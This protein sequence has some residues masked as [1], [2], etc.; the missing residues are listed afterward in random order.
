M[1]ICQSCSWAGRGD[2]IISFPFLFLMLP[3]RFLLVRS[4]WPKPLLRPI[5][6]HSTAGCPVCPPTSLPSGDKALRFSGLPPPHPPFYPLRHE[7]SSPLH[8]GPTP[9]LHRRRPADAEPMVAPATLAL[10]P[11]AAP[12]QPRAALP[13]A[14]ASWF[15]PAIIRTSPSVAASY[16]P[17]RFSGVRRA[18]A[19]DADQQG[20]PEPPEQV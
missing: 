15:A 2:R 13:R 6:S 19:V 7:P 16:P 12:A 20:S 5:I 14:R 3:T 17:R 1:G 11:S 18:V 9:R 8:L 10:R 4:F